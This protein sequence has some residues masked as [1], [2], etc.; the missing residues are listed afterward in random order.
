LTA[1]AP[2]VDFWSRRKARVEAEARAGEQ[3]D[4][5][6]LEAAELAL[7]EEKSDEELLLE[8]ELPDP[9]TLQPGDNIAGFMGKAVPERLRR[10]ALR[11][12]WRINP[13]LANVDGLVDY[14]QDFSDSALAVE[15]LQTAY[16]VGKGMLKHVQEMARQAE[17]KAGETTEPRADA[18]PEAVHAEP[19]ESTAPAESD[20]EAP[21]QMTPA[22]PAE[23]AD[24]EADTDAA[25]D[26]AFAAAAPAPLADSDNEALPLPRRR[27][28]F[29]FSPD[30]SP[31]PRI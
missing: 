7:Q 13:V 20:N 18:A 26:L 3:A 8:L 14:G 15:N 4:Q 28:K 19:G 27:M 21:V 17:E 10:R 25:P 16:Q 1:A 22:G 23:M 12:L 30:K 9:D 6:A 11:Q 24:I 29:Q 5:A 2:P 31:E